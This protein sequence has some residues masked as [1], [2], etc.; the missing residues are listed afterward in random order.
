MQ[1]WDHSISTK[2]LTKSFGWDTHD[3]SLQHDAQEFKRVLFEKLDE[4]MK[5]TAEEGTIQRLF[6]GHY[7]NLIKC[8]KVDY[9][10]T[11]KEPFYDLL[12]NIKEC[13][14]LYDSLDKY[15]EMEKIQGYSTEQY[16]FQDIQMGRLFNSFPPVLQ[17][18][19]QRFEY[20]HMKGTTINDRYEFPLQLDLDRDDGKYLSSEADR[21]VRNLYT[22]HRY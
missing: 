1:H 14:N 12:L 16:G 6:E 8:I 21:S 11:S 18:Q 17:I 13:R 15:V 19:L 9:T 2:N 7:M 22:L 4:S 20:D 3:S 10:S 5:G